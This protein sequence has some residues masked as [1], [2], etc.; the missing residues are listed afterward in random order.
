MQYYTF[1]LDDQSSEYCTIVVNQIGIYCY[2]GLPMGV[3]QSFNF[4]E[5]MEEV[6]RGVDNV[7][8]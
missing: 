7:T 4:A 3:W 5:T 6:L 8:M 1:H 2:S